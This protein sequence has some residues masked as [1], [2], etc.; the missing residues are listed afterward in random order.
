MRKRLK[1]KL[2]DFCTVAFERTRPFA[3]KV[4]A[5]TAT[6]GNPPVYHPSL[7]PCF[8][9]IEESWHVIR[10]ELD[11]VLEERERIPTLQSISPANE[12]LTDDERWQA[13][14]FYSY[15]L[16]VKENC[17]KCP[18]TVRL[19]EGIPG[20]KTA[21][22]SILQARKH[23]RKHRGPYS[24]VMRYH[25]GLIVPEPREKVRIAIDGEIF[26][27]EEG[28]GLIFNDAFQHEVWNDTDGMRVVLFITFDRPIRFPFGLFN[29]GMNKIHEWSSYH[30]EVRRKLKE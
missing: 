14:M 2:E 9:K 4:L 22:F 11:T 8:R 7:F 10:K 30:Q 23:I 25:L 18:E 24:G 6:Y 19:I 1:G 12:A 29:R 26:H 27:W 16:K 28:G 13:F 21:F 17:G 5:K 15:G 3:E 20:L